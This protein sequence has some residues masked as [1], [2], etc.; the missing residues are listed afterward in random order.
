MITDKA[1]G[2]GLGLPIAQEII[3]RHGGTITLRSTDA[4]TTFSIIL[5]L[6]QS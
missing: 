6:E 1:E 3:S 5:P 2:S 4:G